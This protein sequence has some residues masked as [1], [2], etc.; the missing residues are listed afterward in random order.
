MVTIR[1]DAML[2]LPLAAYRAYADRI[3]DGLK[4]AKSFFSARRIIWEKD[5]PYPTQ[6]ITLA[7][8]FASLDPRERTA[9]A[10]DKLD[11]WFWCGVL[12]ELYSSVTETRIAR[13]APE[14]IAWIR[15]A[16]GSPQTIG[17]AIFQDN[18]FDTLRSRLAAAY[19]GI[20]ALLMREGCQD[21][22]SGEP[23]DIMTFFDRQMDIHHVFPAAWCKRQG[24]PPAVYNRI[25]NKTPLSRL[26]NVRVGGD[27][28]SVYL[29][30]I[31]QQDGIPAHRLDAILRTHLIDPTH[32]RQD[33]FEAFMTA[34]RIALGELVA[35]AMRKPIAVGQGS[36]EAEA[37]DDQDQEE[38]AA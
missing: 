34:R 21:F 26:S 6:A 25:L 8:V 29:R 14:L 9:A 28:P 38:E 1:R 11:E 27:A 4:Q 2:S 24:I 16:S 7:A 33:D 19:K 30:R 35:Q 15:G 31:E 17:E 18:R 23:T 5:V 3:E 10:D 32:L 20:H 13:D 12:G 22:I 36:N 37:Y